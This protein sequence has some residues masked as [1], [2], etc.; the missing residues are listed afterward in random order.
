M[1]QTTSPRVRRKRAERRERIVEAAFEA[2]AESG[3]AD[4][5]LNQLARDLDYTPGAL[6]WYFASKEALVVEV[7]KRAFSELAE[8]IRVAREAWEQ[9]AIDLDLPRQVR[10]LHS[11]L[12]AAQHYLRLGGPDHLR[13]LGAVQPRHPHED[14]GDGLLQARKGDDGA[15]QRPGRDAD[16]LPV[17]LAARQPLH[18][19]LGDALPRRRQL[20]PRRMRP[21]VVDRRPP[22]HLP[23][24]LRRP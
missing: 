24:L 2:I 12:S 18:R 17:Q 23:G 13:C 7:Q 11:L 5:S 6:Y 16:H 21:P 1:K 4:F 19:R 8:K 9:R 14:V 20:E 3:P 15:I 10:R 22:K